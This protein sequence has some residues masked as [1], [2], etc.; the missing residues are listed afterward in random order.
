MDNCFHFKQFDLEFGKSSQKVTTDSVLLG[1]WTD[2][3]GNIRNILDVGAGTGLL[4]LMMAQRCPEAYIDAIEVDPFAVDESKANFGHSKWRERLNVYE[5]DF[6]SFDFP[7][8]YD[9][10]ISNPPYFSENT[11]SHNERR[12]V[13]RHETNLNVESLILKS[14]TLLTPD[15]SLAFVCPYRLAAKVLLAKELAGFTSVREARVN[16]VEGK[17][18][19]LSLFQLSFTGNSKKEEITIKDRENKYTEQYISLTSDFYLFL[20]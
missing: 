17:S 3:S 19:Y 13:A 16:T 7:K 14:R 1:A 4:A 6:S 11:F 5:G 12:N 2:V 18:P 8:K 20:H 10:I 15:G 9:L